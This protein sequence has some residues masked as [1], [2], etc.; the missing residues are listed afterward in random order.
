MSIYGDPK[1]DEVV[2]IDTNHAELVAALVTSRKPR[3]VLEL[4]FGAGESCRA[5]LRGLSYNAQ[6][7]EYTVVD[8]WVDFGG[9]QPPAT[10]T[11]EYA[12]INFVTSAENEFVFSCKANFDFIFSDADHFNTQNWFEYVY[13]NLLDREGILIYHDVTN[14]KLFPNLLR[15]YSDTAKNKIDH[16]LFNYNSL[17]TEC[18]DRGLLVIFKH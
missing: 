12:G 18:C 9:T 7:A 15:I 13:A 10:K 3:R 17:K 2:R 1:V 5:I 14:S 6:H 4:G 8:N 11:A 16:M